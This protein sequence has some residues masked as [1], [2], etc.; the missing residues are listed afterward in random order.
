MKKPF[1][2]LSI[3]TAVLKHL[4]IENYKSLVDVELNLAKFNVLVGPN[5]SGKSNL[6]EAVMFF[7]SA[8]GGRAWDFIKGK[9]WRPKVL[10]YGAGPDAPIDLSSLFDGDG[11]REWVY[12]IRIGPESYRES[13][14][15]D[16]A[17]QFAN[18][19]RWHYYRFIP[20]H[21]RNQA[22]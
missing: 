3:R 19:T 10:F 5:N 14:A 20:S 12:S 15:G 1:R 22:G 16:R 13:G 11:G 17:R 18:T 4:K 21:M 2:L 8:L 9:G 7:F 6:M